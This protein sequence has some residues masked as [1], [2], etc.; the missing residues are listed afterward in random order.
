LLWWCLTERRWKILAGG[1]TAASVALAL[2]W[3]WNPAVVGQ[4]L[5]TLTQRPPAQYRSPTLGMVLRLLLGEENFRLQFLALIPGLL[6]LPFYWRR[7]RRAWEWSERLPMLAF[8]SLL[9]AAYGAW[10]FDLV[11][12]LPALLQVVAALRRSERGTGWRVAAAVY[13]A[14]NVVASLQLSASA[15]Y[16]DFL[17]LPP[18]LLLAYLFLLPRRPAVAC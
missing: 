18:A 6:W 7:H 10:L 12:L 13:L 15:E 3:A 9:T 5:H 14:F 2:A 16:F 1:L 11:L 4:Y 17:W 8:V